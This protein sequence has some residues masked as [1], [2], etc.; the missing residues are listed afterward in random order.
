MNAPW[1]AYSQAFNESLVFSSSPSQY[2]SVVLG[3]M[4]PGNT[5][6]IIVVILSGVPT[7]VQQGI[8]KNFMII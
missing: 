7:L 3:Q 1:I 6:D 8:N 2:Y 4:L 5:A